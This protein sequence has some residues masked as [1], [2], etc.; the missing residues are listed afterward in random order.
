MTTL[1]AAHKELFNRMP[2]ECFDS[3]ETL[4]AHCDA[5]RQNS[6]DMWEPPEK[7]MLTHDITLCEKD[8]SL[9]VS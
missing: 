1:T 9:V 5:Q 3:F 4:Y 6:T 8:Q 2:D 7:V